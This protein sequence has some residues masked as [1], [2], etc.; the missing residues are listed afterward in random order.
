MPHQEAE[1]EGE[2]HAKV[3]KSSVMACI[4]KQDWAMSDSARISLLVFL[5]RPESY[6]L[7]SVLFEEGCVESVSSPGAWYESRLEDLV[8]TLDCTYQQC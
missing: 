7:M 3:Q 1:L 8:P 2:S 5:P 6:V 4:L